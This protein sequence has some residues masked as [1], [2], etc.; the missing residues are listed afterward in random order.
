MT[1]LYLTHHGPW[2]VTSG[3]RVRDAAL[4]PKLTQLADVEVWA[5]SRTADIDSAA[6]REQALDFPVRVFVDEAARRAFPTRDSAAVR[7]LLQDRIEAGTPYDVVHVEGHYLFHLLPAQ[8]ARRTLL[9]EH[10]IESYLLC[11][12]GID[13]RGP[14]VLDDVEAVKAAEVQAWSR[15]GRV[16]VLSE[17]DRQR[18]LNRV[19]SVGVDV[20]ANGADHVPLRLPTAESDRGRINVAPRIGFLA[21]YA[22]QPNQDAVRWLL[23]AIFPQI[24]GSIPR[25]E[26]LL[27]GH[28]LDEAVSWDELPPGVVPLGWIDDIADFWSSTD[29]MICP[30]RIGGGMKVKLTEAVRAGCFTVTTGVA[31]EGMPPEVVTATIRADDAD[32]LV[33]GVVR[34]CT[35]AELR[36]TLRA[37]LAQAQRALPTWSMAASSIARHWTEV[38]GRS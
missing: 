34:V 11:Q 20:C 27:A 35:D 4:L 12:R 5:I 36:G 21:N 22:Y 17:E 25:A 32:G 30:L 24:R 16:L 33:A 18:I 1:V 9:V 38:R 8:L 28:R 23:D 13:R 7:A 6:L 29:I 26:L 3:G 10:N 37:R 14:P 2:P 19:P 31:L 15:A